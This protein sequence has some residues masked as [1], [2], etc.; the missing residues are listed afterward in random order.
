MKTN[1]RLNPNRKQKK[2]GG[3]AAAQLPSA[4]RAPRGGGVGRHTKGEGDGWDKRISRN[5]WWRLSGGKEAGRER[6]AKRRA[7]GYVQA[8]TA[9]QG[10]GWRNTI[11]AL[12]KVLLKFW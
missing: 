9:L 5:G 10:D 2:V 3:A 4:P 8:A 6:D 12:A 7:Q 1:K 11:G